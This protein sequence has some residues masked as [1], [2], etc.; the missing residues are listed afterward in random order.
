MIPP[1]FARQRIPHP[2][3]KSQ[4]P[5]TPGDWYRWTIKYSPI[6][7]QTSNEF[8]ILTI[9]TCVVFFFWGVTAFATFAAGTVFKVM[10][11]IALR[12]D[13][14]HCSQ[15]VEGAFIKSRGS[16]VGRRCLQTMKLTICLESPHA[17]Q[18]EPIVYTFV[19]IFGILA[20]LDPLL[21]I[22]VDALSGNLD[23]CLIPDSSLI[24]VIKDASLACN[25]NVMRLWSVT[26]RFLATG[27]HCVKP[28][29]AC[30]PQPRPLNTNAMQPF[31]CCRPNNPRNN[32]TLA[33]SGST[34]A[35]TKETDLRA[36]PWPSLC[37][38]V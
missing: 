38:S 22:I 5:H 28:L 19:C 2:N 9:G 10:M 26:P 7:N 33:T 1:G 24:N 25:A 4:T 20:S 21:I 35:S 14:H 16:E 23:P 3:H 11:H 36:L 15:H 32:P 29:L 18:V 37:T 13:R 30:K 8:A 17:P 27:I 12:L 31:V 34:F 6:A